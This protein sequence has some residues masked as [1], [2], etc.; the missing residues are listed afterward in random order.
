VA[1]NSGGQAAGLADQDRLE[2]LLHRLRVKAPA[3]PFDV[4]A[5]ERVGDDPPAPLA[6][7][8]LG[9]PGSCSIHA[10]QATR[11]LGR[12]ARLRARSFRWPAQIP[13]FP[14]SL[15]QSLARSRSSGKAEG[16][17]LFCV[18]AIRAPLF[19]ICLLLGL[20]L[21]V[22]GFGVAGLSAALTGWGLAGQRGCAGRALAAEGLAGAPCA[23][24]AACMLVPARFPF[25]ASHSIIARTNFNVEPVRWTGPWGGEA[26][27]S[28]LLTP[29]GCPSKGSLSSGFFLGWGILFSEAKRI[30][31]LSEV[32]L[33]SSSGLSQ[34]I[35][36]LWR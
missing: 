30:K 20:V 8:Q 18:W 16:S 29:C 14:G 24:H 12:F 33:L 26:T 9:C 10:R 17:S 19:L 15:A 2:L 4:D 3:Q 11:R 35:R 25:F 7:R 22:G 27:W 34:M 31:F 1:F 23:S 28:T 5:F 36:G 6:G 32:V 21:L 13:V